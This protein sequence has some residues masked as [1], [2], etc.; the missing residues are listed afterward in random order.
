MLKYTKRYLFYIVFT[1][2]VLIICPFR[3]K[4]DYNHI[5]CTYTNVNL[6]KSNVKYEFEILQNQDDKNDVILASSD[7]GYAM[8]FR[9]KT[10][11]LQSFVSGG[12][13]ICPSTLYI[14]PIGDYTQDLIQYAEFSFEKYEESEIPDIH[15]SNY[16]ANLTSQRYFNASTK[17]N[18]SAFCKNSA[19][20][21]A[22]IGY[23]ILVIKILI[24]LILIIIGM[25]DLGKAI[26]SNDEKAISK[27]A[28][29]LLKRFIAA[30]L[31]FF[32]PTIISAIFNA[33]KI[34]DLNS[35]DANICV[36]CVTNVMGE[37]TVYVVDN[38]KITET[39]K[40]TC[41]ALSK[42]VVGSLS[43]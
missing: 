20:I 33:I 37:F 39:Y 30:V 6:D 21:W 35:S 32:V 27:S 43:N 41:S 8:L 11:F 29:S 4:A 14:Y 10:K 5:Y 24:P 25:I 16:E 2:V 19:N 15:L 3:V 28:T 9:D 31:V 36:Q 1:I 40:T 42:S 38:G 23:I 22:I 18:S 34:G 7:V 17:I 26:V 13:L 12:K